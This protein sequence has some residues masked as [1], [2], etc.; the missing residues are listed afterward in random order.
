MFERY[1]FPRAEAPLLPSV[2]GL[3]F[4]GVDEKRKALMFGPWFLRR[5]A[6]GRGKLFWWWSE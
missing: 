6:W 2:F 3:V 5:D 1:Y 4:L